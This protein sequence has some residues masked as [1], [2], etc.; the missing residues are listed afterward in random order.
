MGAISRFLMIILRDCYH[1]FG[2][3]GIAVIVFTFLS[4]LILLPAALWTYLNSIKMVR[5][6]PEINE[7]KVKYFGQPDLIGEEQ[8]KLFHRE[9][10]SP[11]VSVIPTFLQ[12]FLLIAVVGAIRSGIEDPEIHMQFLGLDLGSV[13]NEKGVSLL[14]SPL[15]AGLSSLVMCVAQNRS[16]VLQAEQSRWNQYGVLA[17]S[18][19]LS[20]YLGWFVP[21]ATC[22]YWICSNLLSVVQLY[23]MNAIVRP[24]RFINYERLEKSRRQLQEL[25]RGGGKKEGL[26]SESRKREKRD[27]K[28]FFSVTNKHLVFYSES[29]GFYKYFQG[30]IEYIL[31][32]TNLTIH[33]I[34]SD[35]NDRI[36]ALQ[37]ENPQIR[38]YYIG[39][40]KLITLM[41]KMDAD[42]VVMTMPD[43]ENFHI[44]RS[45]LRDDI[46]YIF[47][48]HDMNNHAMLMRRGCTDHFDTVFLAGKHQKEEEEEIERVYRL[49]PRN[50]VEIG[51]PLIDSMRAAYRAA[52][53]PEKSRKRILIAPSWQ[54]DNIV[55]SCLEQI[56][57]QLKG[58]PYDVVVRPHPQEVRLKQDY[59]ERL[60][61][62][63]ANT[64]IEI[65]TDFSSNSSV[66]EADLLITDWSGISW[67]YAFTTGRPVLFINT[68]MKIINPDY[69]EIKTESIN[70]KLRDQLGK[71]LD[72][73]QLDRTAET[74]RGLL[75]QSD[76]YRE[77]NEQ[78][79]REY[80]YHLDGSAEI[81]GKY[82]IQTIQKK[83]EE[84]K[85]KG[86]KN[87]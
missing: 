21:L 70:L 5:I 9:G 39:E 11:F 34:T 31:K 74:V 72:L 53:H 6:Q 35:K 29:S 12:L 32:H 71:S 84:K 28:R 25:N 38:A 79:A 14:W 47:A 16:N 51:Y 3:Y 75:A 64:G 2:N 4:K 24:K 7:L 76:T 86:E 59:M 55:D 49:K 63:Y 44:K 45:Y 26:F 36:F 78:L 23:I 57:D 19:G 15:L 46:E 65:Q 66:M 8:N 73:N 10:Y 33:Y 69:Q 61:Q 37:E 20:L 52:E 40:N 41:M 82:I 81:G 83:I 77:R 43:L 13:P 1:A 50:L 80:L 30:Y 60:K 58:Q 87:T 54:S 56:L 17:F 67:E 27:Y 42:V 48:Q 18:V 22:L 68:P 85:R 62:K